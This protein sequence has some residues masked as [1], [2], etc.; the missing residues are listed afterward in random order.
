MLSPQLPTPPAA[1]NVVVVVVVG[2]AAADDVDGVDLKSLQLYID[3]YIIIHRHYPILGGFI[4][5]LKI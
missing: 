1:G 3:Y 2:Q 5:G 4:H